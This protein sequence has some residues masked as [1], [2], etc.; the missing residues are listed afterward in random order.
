MFIAD[1]IPESDW[2]MVSVRRFEIVGVDWSLLDDPDQF[3][4]GE[5]VEIVSF[6]FI[7]P[8][9]DVVFQE[10]TAGSFG[11]RNSAFLG[12]VCFVDRK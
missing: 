10:Q 5:V 6:S 11:E 4:D 8:A 3:F 7:R 1:D 2:K 9:G 12:G